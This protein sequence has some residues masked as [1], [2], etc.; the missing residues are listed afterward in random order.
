MHNNNTGLACIGLY[1][2]NAIAIESE[3]RYSINVKPKA[4]RRA[5]ARKERLHCNVHVIAEIK[6]SMDS[7]WMMRSQR[8]IEP[9]DGL[10][11]LRPIGTAWMCTQ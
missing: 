1:R 11:S 4:D 3:A 2:E 6:R 8:S 10:E 7:F 9:T 5:P